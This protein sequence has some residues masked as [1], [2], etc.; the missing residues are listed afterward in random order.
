MSTAS[1]R[2]HTHDSTSRYRYYG[3]STVPTDEVVTSSPTAVSGSSYHH[4]MPGPPDRTS[5]Y[6]PHSLNLNGASGSGS[7]GPT[8]YAASG[9]A[10]GQ[11]RR[12]PPPRLVQRTSFTS[13]AQPSPTSASRHHR[14]ES[15]DGSLRRGSNASDESKME[16]HRSGSSSSHHHEHRVHHNHHHGHRPPRS[17]SGHAH[18]NG[19][20]GHEHRRRHRHREVEVV[21]E[22]VLEMEMEDEVVDSRVHVQVHNMEQ[23]WSGQY[24]LYRYF[25]WS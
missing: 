16:H 19:N 7:G 2:R 13:H 10:S 5:S 24:R 23:F 17:H 12:R 15:G 18:E 6:P 22:E 21:D 25:R 9:S 3:P 8:G 11:P 4:G 1:P 14:T 20:G